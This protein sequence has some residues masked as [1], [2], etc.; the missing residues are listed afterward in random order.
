MV[1][2]DTVSSCFHQLHLEKGFPQPSLSLAQTH[3]A[4]RAAPS[5]TRAFQAHTP[6]NVPSQ[7]DSLALRVNS[8]FSVPPPRTDQGRTL[9]SDTLFV[10]DAGP[11]AAAN[12]QHLQPSPIRARKAIPPRGRPR[13]LPLNKAVASGLQGFDPRFGLCL[14]TGSPTSLQQ[15]QLGCSFWV[16]SCSSLCLKVSKNP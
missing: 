10:S 2:G 1:F 14:H 3:S 8:F 6:R 5:L 16:S 15:G 4:R 9:A 11:S 7:Q 12:C 13:V